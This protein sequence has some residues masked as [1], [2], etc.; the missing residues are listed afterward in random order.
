MAIKRTFNGATLIKPGAYSKT[1]VE[2]LTGFPLLPAGTVGIIGEAAGG[3][4][5][6]LDILSGIGVQQ[7]KERYKS[8][9]IADALELLVNPSKDPRI[10]N[11]ASTICVW[12]TN[13]STASSLA[14][15]NDAAA[16]ATLLTLTSKNYG[17]DENLVNV[18]V[19]EGETVD[20]DASLTGTLDGPFT[21]ANG[22]TLILNVNGTAYTFTNTL[23]GSQTATAVMGELNTGAR[24]A[25][26]KPI[27]AS[28]DG[29][30][31]KITID[32]AT[33]TFAFNEY[34]FIDVDATSTIDT[35]LGITGEIR[36]HKGSRIFTIKNSTG[37]EEV[38]SELGGL[39]QL[40]IQYTGA[41]TAATLTLNVQSSQLKLTT[42]ITGASGDNLD[43]VL[44]DAE[45]KN[46]HT[47]QTLVDT[48]NS[49]GKYAASV[50]GLNPQ[51]NANELDQYLSLKILQVPAKLR[52][53]NAEI[54]NDLTLF[55][56][57]V[58]AAVTDN[59]YYAVAPVASPT[60]LTGAADGSSANSDYAAGFEAFKGERINKVVPLISK[61][62]GAVSIDSVNALAQAHAAWGWSTAGKNERE[63]FCSY[64]GTKAE[65]KQGARDLNSAF[66]SLVGQEVQVLNR[67]SDLEWKDPWALACVL[68]GLRSG[69]E[70][71]EP[72]TFKI[73]NVNDIRSPS[74]DFDPKADFA[75]LIEAGV[76]IV[77]PLDSGGF[78]CVLGN[79]TYSS[80]QNFVW[81][82]ESV[83]QVAGYVAYDLRYNLELQFTGTKAK[84]GTAASIA[85][86]CKARMTTYLN[87]DLIVGDDLN[88]GLGYKNL[89]IF[90]EGN[91]AVINVSITPVQG[92]DFLLPTI[93]LAD[94][95]QT[96]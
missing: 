86:F 50:L 76:T 43:I 19:D 6:V 28:L 90:V 29:Q 17:A 34:G 92:L 44:E 68:A 85:N 33:L 87:G 32:T 20:S 9:P 95:R 14:L 53:D 39:D 81:N 26:S 60:F 18:T 65:I 11:G 71:G 27:V 25:P 77:E 54:A 23:V 8:G 93:Y 63:A 47:L 38:S 46:K 52:A 45:G 89:R 59:A 62:T 96:A 58:D 21:V 56:S 61:D 1:V 91:T 88:E 5:G 35:I 55:S 69:A 22:N 66:A 72:L 51:R 4:P 3:E 67:Y 48:L 7:A 24:W 15:A 80:D 57:Y 82:R 37:K 42:A 84:T 83:V 10:P 79:T 74:N 36:G 2:N 40:Q 75:E 31:I 70:V 13:S 30:K 73:L 49:T 78:R 64:S 12:K 94:I 16:P 41:G